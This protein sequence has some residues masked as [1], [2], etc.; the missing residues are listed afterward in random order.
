MHPHLDGCPGTTAFA[1]TPRAGSSASFGAWGS[2]GIGPSH[3]K[4]LLEA[5]CSTLTVRSGITYAFGRGLRH[6]LACGVSAA[7]SCL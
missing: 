7:G 6:C 3:L 2:S 1:G 5:R 4:S